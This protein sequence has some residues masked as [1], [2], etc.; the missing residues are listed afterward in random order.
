MNFRLFACLFVLLLGSHLCHVGALW[1]E[2]NL[3][4]AASAQMIQGRA[5]YR[6]I[7]FDKPPIWPA[8]YL[9]WGAKYGWPLRVAG[10]V[11]AL[12]V[13][14]LTF[15]A[16]RVRW[17]DSEARWAASLMAFFLIFDTHS[18]VLPLAVDLLMLAPH[19]AAIGFAWQGR[20]LWSGICAGIAFCINAKALFVLAA[21]AAWIPRS[22]PLLTLGFALPNALAAASLAS[23][24]AFSDYV[25]QVW[26]WGRIYAAQTF[27][28]RPWQNGLVRTLNW[29][30]FH[31]AIVIAAFHAADRDRWK[32]V[33]WVAISLCAIALGLRFFPRYYFQLLPI[34]VLAAARGIAHMPRLR[35]AIVLGLLLIPLIRFGPRYATLASDR[36][37][38]RP[39]EWTDLAMDR[40]SREAAQIVRSLA[41][42]G[43]TLLVWGY[44]PELFVYTGLPAASR[45]LDSQALTGVAADRHLFE[46]LSLAPEWARTNRQELIRSSPAFILDGLGLYNPK[47][48]IREFPDL[49]EFLA[50]YSLAGQSRYTKIYRRT[51]VP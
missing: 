32:W 6:D 12:L 15:W 37:A 45:F 16:A 30:G 40:D 46:S 8:V 31:A 27:A 33:W 2:E 24:G 35:R 7:W 14:W 38:G 3:S 10:A 48:D 25:D 18:A 1:A 50:R 44:R 41:K 20:P 42:P 47:L 34:V 19:L 26:R 17:S 9:L 5:L 13:C 23:S 39:H 28:G 29:I 43:D 51:A 22:I 36:F 49:R 4:L 11:Y 21:C